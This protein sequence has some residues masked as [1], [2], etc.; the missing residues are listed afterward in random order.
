M[1][2]SAIFF[3]CCFC[4]FAEVK[5]LTLR[6]AI[7]LALVQSP[8][9]IL[10]RLDQQKLRDQ[11]TIAR[12]PFMPK[13]Y[14]GSGAAWTSGF[15]ASVEGAAPAIFNARTQMALF[16][17]PQHYQ[18]AQ[19]NENLRTAELDA[20]RQRDEVVYRVASLFL[21]A[22]QAARNVAFA[23][24]E[25]DNL[26]R[27]HELVD[28]RV[29]E[30]RE[31]PIESKKANIA[32]LRARQRMD[33]LEADL[34]NAEISL[35]MVLGLNPDDRVQAS[36][37]ERPVLAV[38]T[39]EEQSIQNA[40]AN[41]SD[42]KRLD[43]AIQSKMLEIKGYRAERLPKVNLVAQYELFAKYYYQ[44]YFASFQRNSGQLGASIEIPLIVGRAGRA[45]VSQAE[46]DIAK[47]RIEENRTR[48]Q[49]TANLRSA[50]QDLK[51]AESALDLAR[52][53]LEVTRDQL[54]I[55][56]AQMNEGRAPLT[57]VEESRALENDKWMAFYEAQHS[58]ES[59][60]LMVLRRTGTLLSALK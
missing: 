34:E 44:N 22:E 21:D 31:L 5:T 10:A 1:R 37:E 2:T 4:L 41:S 42:L 59:A 46:V 58:A 20:G 60:R 14:G 39:S 28:Q 51:R 35:A 8:D 13:V 56:L 15:P 40:I 36:Q 29:A 50:F 17:R 25:A 32:M 27:V 45:Y 38:P 48:S 18:V 43:S 49:I 23:R 11:V 57:K 3:V 12:D 6:Q 54:T 7:D 19:S 55:D 33:S 24:Q 16:D 52:L 9:L 47:L 53:D 30:G 26:A